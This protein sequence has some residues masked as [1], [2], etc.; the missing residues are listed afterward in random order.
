MIFFVIED[1]GDLWEEP[2]AMSFIGFYN[3]FVFSSQS[4][5]KG[6]PE[7]LCA[8]LCVCVSLW[9]FC[10]RFFCGW[11]VYVFSVIFVCFFG[12]VLFFAWSHKNVNQSL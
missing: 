10:S 7:Q 2:I 12:F 1:K 9:S 5:R 8:S 4:W 6:L 3:I 11:I